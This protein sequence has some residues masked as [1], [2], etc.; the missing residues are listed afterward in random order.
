[1]TCVIMCSSNFLKPSFGN[2]NK[3]INNIIKKT[4]IIKII[5]NNIKIIN[6]TRITLTI[7]I[8][9]IEFYVQ[10]ELKHF[11]NDLELIQ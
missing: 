7:T 2:N 11:S 10:E 1:M 4:I 9:K 5:K 8:I 3:K 6:I